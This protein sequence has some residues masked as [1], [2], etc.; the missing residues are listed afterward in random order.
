MPVKQADLDAQA[1]AELIM[2]YRRVFGTPD[3]KVIFAD[4]M[5]VLG[6]NA[7]IESEAQSALHNGALV[8]MARA[9]IFRQWNT[10][11]L[12]DAY[13]SLPYTPPQEEALRG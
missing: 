6:L 5:D 13:F 1:D 9:G 4:I 2:T 11:P 7:T 12:L 3:G 10:Q 8:I